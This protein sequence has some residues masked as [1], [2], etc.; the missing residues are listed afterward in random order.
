VSV[1]ALCPNGIRTNQEATHKIE[2]HGLIGRMVSMDPDQVAARAIKGL[3]A[4]KA[5][6]VPGFI[7]R[8]IALVGKHTPRSIVCPVVSMFYRKTATPGQSTSHGQTG[9][10]AIAYGG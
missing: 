7:N 2:A 9:R 8:V 10:V 3:F 4:G 1:S 5:V 6:I